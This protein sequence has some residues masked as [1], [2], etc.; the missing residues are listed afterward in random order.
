MIES[1]LDPELLVVLDPSVESAVEAIEAGVDHVVLTGSAQTG[2]AVLRRLAETL[3]PSTMELSGCDAVYV[4][5]GAEVDHTIRALAFGLRFNGS[6]TCMA[7]RRV[8][9][10]GMAEAAAAEF[11]SKLTAALEQIDPVLLPP[12]TVALLREMAADARTQGADVR[13]D[14]L[15]VTEFDGTGLGVTGLDAPGQ[16]QCAGVTLI[17]GAIPSLLSMQRDIFAPVMSVMRAAESGEAL[18]ASA[19]CPFA[20][21]ASVFG[22]EAEA[23]MLASR[24]QAGTVLIN[25]VVFPTTDPRIPFGG[26]GRSGFG[27]TRGAE[28]LL[29]MSAPRTVQVRRD[30]S[31]R[32]YEPT[33]DAHAQLFAGPCAVAVW[34]WHRKTMVCSETDLSRRPKS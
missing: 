28:G 29:A 30:R 13:R 23:N 12:K 18:A 4:L 34:G 19:A 31:R 26:R 11:E 32:P 7:P 6:F 14:G 3:T 16:Y 20:L 27:V 24:I 5:P 2:K 33:G 25:D 8:F 22:P 10:V 17:T 1:G 15:D 9:L 21:T